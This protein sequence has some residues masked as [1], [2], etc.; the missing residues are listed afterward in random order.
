MNPPMKP[1][2]LLMSQ[3]VHPIPPLKGAAVEQWIDAVAHRMSRYQ[4]HIVSVPHPRRPDSE[5]DGG[6]HYRRVRIGRAYNRVFRKLTRLDPWSYADRVAAYAR[7]I[8]P[9]IIHVHNAPRLLDPIVRVLSASSASQEGRVRVIL[10]MHN[11]KHDAVHV[12][13]DALAA[14]SGYVRDWYRERGFAADRFAVVRNG[15]DIAAY[16]PELRAPETLRRLRQRHGVPDDRFVVLF[17]GRISPEKGADLLVEAMRSL[18]AQRFHLV[19]V[20]EWPRGEASRSERVRFAELLSGRLSGLPHTI[21]DT[22]PPA[23]MPAMYGLGDLLVIPSR[24][25]EPFSMVAIEGM[26]AGIPV[27]ALR[28]GGM[29]EYMVDGENAR[30]LDPETAPAGLAAAILA[31]AQEA[32][33]LAGMATNARRMVASRFD[34]KQVADETEQLYDEVL[35]DDASPGRGVRP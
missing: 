2:V 7:S 8:E 17:V 16:P 29:A 12:H 35:R 24:F 22:V 6:V 5:V 32:E 1:R 25:E 15:V 14:C 9:A 26:A 34:W 33:R 23:D 4:P 11:E 3:E 21:L 20:G 30:V 18:D 10:H 27:I 28:R 13:V 19:L 31:A